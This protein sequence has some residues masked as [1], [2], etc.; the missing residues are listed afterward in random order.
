MK[1][2]LIFKNDISEIER[3]HEY[4]VNIGREE[5][6]DEETLMGINLAVEEAVVNVI[7]YAYPE[8]TEGAVVIDCQ[9]DASGKS[10]VFMIKDRGR[11]FDPTKVEEADT[12]LSAEERNIGGLGIHLVRNIMD[13]MSYERTPDGYNVLTLEKKL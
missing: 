3:L 4:F 13:S 1:H 10:I 7:N 9:K 6:I 11:E 2:E 8:H 12:T 5:H